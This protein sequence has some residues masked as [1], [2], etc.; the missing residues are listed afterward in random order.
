MIE[1]ILVHDLTVILELTLM[2]IFGI[3]IGYV[4]CINKHK[5]K[6]VI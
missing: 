4:M 6:K 2:F 5:I 1:C 3:V